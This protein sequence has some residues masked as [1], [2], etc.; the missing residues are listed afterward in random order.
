MKKLTLILF[1][2]SAVFI[3]FA[4]DTNVLTGLGEPAY[5]VRI[6]V[7][8]PRLTTTYARGY[9]IANQ[10][11]TINFLGLGVLGEINNGV[12]TMNYGWIGKDYNETYMSF[13][14]SG[15]VGIGTTTPTEKLSIYG[16][17]NSAP[18]VISLESSRNDDGFVEVGAISTKNNGGEI[19]RVGM[20]RGAGTYHGL[21]NFLVKPTNDAPL[22]EAMRIAENGNLL[23]GK[24]TQSNVSYKLDINGK[25]RANE[26]VVNTTGADFVFEPDYKLPELAELEKFV[27]TNKHL[28][29]IP[30]AKQ[31]VENGINLGELNIKLLQKVEELTLHLI[32]K[33]K[34]AMQLEKKLNSQTELLAAF[35]ERLKKMEQSNIQNPTTNKK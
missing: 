25:A 23:I 33:D 20:L 34:N 30:T 13:L 19:A 35:E 14:Q 29:E 24:I 28:P 27:K 12:S 16:T 10:D 22:I 2:I 32:A 5:G 3:A 4:Q 8:F 17:V 9:Y 11:N 21:I 15:N 26:I 7:N 18:G 1:A 31:M 6:K